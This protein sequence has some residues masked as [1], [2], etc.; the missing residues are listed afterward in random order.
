MAK[1]EVKQSEQY[2]KVTYFGQ[3]N[4]FSERLTTNHE[5]YDCFKEQ[6]NKYTSEIYRELYFMLNSSE[7]ERKKVESKLIK[8]YNP[9]CNNIS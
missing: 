7:E 5:N 9:P 6:A 4:N 2:Y 8:Q 1:T 3:T